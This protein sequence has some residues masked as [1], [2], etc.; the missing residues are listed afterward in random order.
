MC[1]LLTVLLVAC[2]PQE[3]FPLE[4]F[5]PVY[6]VL[7]LNSDTKRLQATQGNAREF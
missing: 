1:M 3:S 5:R 6:H 2:P 4:S 7:F